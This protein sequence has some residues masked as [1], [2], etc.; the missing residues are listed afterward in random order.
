MVPSLSPMRSAASSRA[1]TPALILLVDDNHDGVVARRSVLEE[2]GY[3]VACACCGADALELVCK[4]NFDL[5]ITDYKM[6]PMDGIELIAKMRARGF[7]KPAILLAGLAESLALHHA[8][9][10]ADIVI[11]KNANEISVL[12]RQTKR[13]LTP[14][15]PVGSFAGAKKRASASGGER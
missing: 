3:K 12:M 11:P 6:A 13:L 8:D 15:K 7:E 2:L 14:K 9:T 10:G 1:Q 4:E 5:V